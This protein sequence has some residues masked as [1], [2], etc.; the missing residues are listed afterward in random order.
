MRAKSIENSALPPGDAVVKKQV[1]WRQNYTR[2]ACVPTMILL[3]FV[4]L[5]GTEGL[6][7]FSCLP[8]QNPWWS[9]GRFDVS[10]CAT[11]V[12]GDNCAVSCSGPPN[13]ISGSDTSG[14]CTAPLEPAVTSWPSCA[15]KA[16]APNAPWMIEAGTTTMTI[17]WQDMGLNDCGEGETG[18]VFASWVLNSKASSTSSWQSSTGT[19]NTAVSCASYT[20]C[21]FNALTANTRHDFKVKATCTDSNLNSDWSGIGTHSTLPTPAG[22]PESLTVADSATTSIKW[23][24]SYSA[25]RG[26][27]VHAGWEAQIREPSGAWLKSPTGCEWPHFGQAECRSANL[28]CHRH[29]QFRVRELCD[30][31]AANSPWSTALPASTLPTHSYVVV[32][33]CSVRAATAP[34]WFA[35]NALTQA[36]YNSLILTWAAGTRNSCDFM[37]WEVLMQ[38]RVGTVESDWE[39]VAGCDVLVSRSVVSCTAMG[40]T[41]PEYRY[42]VRETCV[43]PMANSITSI[44]SPWVERILQQ[45]DTP[46]NVLLSNASHT[47]LKLTWGA[48]TLNDCLFHNYTVRLSPHDG[49]GAA[50]IVWTS[51]P[52]GC[53]YNP[54]IATTE[55]ELKN[56]ASGTGYVASV[57][58]GCYRNSADSA[59]AA[60]TPRATTLP[61]LATT[62]SPTTSLISANGLQVSWTAPSA[63][64]SC[65]FVRWQFEARESGTRVW[66][67][68]SGA[69]ITISPLQTRT[70]AEVHIVELSCDSTYH[71]R[72]R[73]VCSDPDANSFWAYVAPFATTAGGACAKRATPPEDVVAQYA[74][75]HSLFV[76]FRPGEART[77]EFSRFEVQYLAAN[78]WVSAFSGD[79]ASIT[80]RENPTCTAN[81]LVPDTEYYF[82]AREVCTVS[83][84]TSQWSMTVKP[85]RTL[86]AVPLT[87]LEAIPRGDATVNPTHM[88]LVF[89]EPVMLASNRWTATSWAT[90]CSADVAND[91]TW[92]FMQDANF[93]ADAHVT[94]TAQAAGTALPSQTTKCCGSTAC[95]P[96]CTLQTAFS[97]A[98]EICPTV[99]SKCQCADEAACQAEC[100]ELPSASGNN[101]EL[102]SDNLTAQ[103]QFPDGLPKVG[104]PYIV[105]ISRASIHTLTNPAR[106]ISATSWNFTYRPAAPSITSMVTVSS[107]ATS[108]GI[109]VAWTK[110]CSFTCRSSPLVELSTLGEY[111]QVMPATIYIS[112]L[113]PGAGYTIECTGVDKVLP[114]VQATES[115]CCFRTDYDTNAR[116]SSLQ[117]KVETL[118]SGV[119]TASTYATLSPAFNADST[120]QAYAV[121]VDI[122]GYK[123]ACGI[124]PSAD[125][126]VFYRVTVEPVAASTFAT[127]VMD[128]PLGT[129][130]STMNWPGNTIPTTS[131]TQVIT[132]N[133]QPHYLGGTQ[134]VASYPVTITTLYASLQ[135]ES[136]STSVDYMLPTD[137]SASVTV[138]CIMD[139]SLVSSMPLASLIIKFGIFTQA[140]A[141]G[142]Q[143]DVT[144]PQG[145]GNTMKRFTLIAGAASAYGY[146]LPV[147]IAYQSQEFVSSPPHTVSFVGPVVN[148]VDIYVGGTQSSTA[149][150]L[151]TNEI[152]V[153]GFN[154]G[155]GS[156]TSGARIRVSTTAALV[157]DILYLQMTFTG[158]QSSYNGDY[159]VIQAG[160]PFPSP[161]A[162][163]YETVCDRT[164]PM[165]YAANKGVFCW[166]SISNTWRYELVTSGSAVSPTKLAEFNPGNYTPNPVGATMVSGTLA[167]TDN[168][169]SLYLHQSYRLT[170][171]S[172]FSSYDGTYTLILP[173]HVLWHSHASLYT[174]CDTRKHR[175]AQLGT[176]LCWVQSQT[177]WILYQSSGATAIELGKISCTAYNPLP[178][179]CS[180][181]TGQLTS[182]AQARRLQDTTDKEIYNEQNDNKFHR[183]SSKRPAP[184]KLSTTTA[185]NLCGTTTYISTTEVRCSFEPQLQAQLHVML[186]IQSSAGAWVAAAI[187]DNY[188]SNQKVMMQTPTL[189]SITPSVQDWYSLSNLDVTGTNFPANS[190]MVGSLQIWVSASSVTPTLPNPDPADYL[191]L[192]AGS[193]RTSDTTILCV[194]NTGMNGSILK[195]TNPNVWLQTSPTMISPMA[196]GLISL[197]Q[198]NLSR[199][200]RSNDN[201]IAPVRFQL[202]GSE[203]GTA[204]WNGDL[205]VSIVSKGQATQ[206]SNAAPFLD[207][208]TTAAPSPSGAS[209]DASNSSSENS[210]SGSRLLTAAQNDNVTVDCVIVYRADGQITCDVTTGSLFTDSFDDRWYNINTTDPYHQY[211]IEVVLQYVNTSNPIYSSRIEARM[212][213]QVELARCDPGNRRV[214]KDVKTCRECAQ[215]T[216]KGISSSELHCHNCSIGFWQSATGASKCIEC[217][218]DNFTTWQNASASRYNCLCNEG[219]YRERPLVDPGPW[220]TGICLACPHGGKCDGR[221]RRPYSRAGYWSPGRQIFWDCQPPHACEEGTYRYRNKCAVSRNAMSRVCSMCAALYYRYRG[222]CY[223]C[224]FITTTVSQAGPLALV[225]LLVFIVVPCVIRDHTRKHTVLKLLDALDEEKEANGEVEEDPKV[226]KA[227]ARGQKNAH[228]KAKKKRFKRDCCD[229][230]AKYCDPCKIC[231]MLPLDKLPKFLQETIVQPRIRMVALVFSKFQ[232]LWALYLMPY[233]WPE[234]LKYQNEWFAMFVFDLDVIRPECSINIEY[235]QKFGLQ[236]LA[237]FFTSF[238]I[239]LG[240]KV[241]CCLYSDPKH[242]KYVHFPSAIRDALSTQACL[243]IMSHLSDDL[244]WIKCHPCEGGTQQCLNEH[245]IIK[246]NTQDLVFG[247]ITVVS[248]VDIGLVICPAVTYI[249]FGLYKSWMW[250]HGEGNG[251]NRKGHLPWHIFVSDFWVKGYKGYESNLRDEALHLGEYIRPLLQRGK[252][253]KLHDMWDRCIF[254]TKIDKWHQT[255]KLVETSIFN[256]IDSS[257]KRRKI[258]DANASLEHI[259]K[260]D[261]RIFRCPKRGPCYYLLCC[262]GC[263]KKKTVV[264]PSEA[265]KSNKK[266][267]LGKCLSRLCFC[268]KLCL[269]CCRICFMADLPSRPLPR[270]KRP[271]PYLQDDFLE[272]K[273]PMKR[274]NEVVAGSPKIGAIARDK[275]YREMTLEDHAKEAQIIHEELTQA[276]LKNA[277]MQKKHD[278]HQL[279]HLLAATDEFVR[280]V[281]HC[282]GILDH[283]SMFWCYSWEFILLVQKILTVLVSSLAPENQAQQVMSACMFFQLIVLIMC[284]DLEPF[285]WNVLNDI[286]I[287]LDLCMLYMVILAQLDW[288]LSLQVVSTG[289]V[290]IA[291]T[292]LTLRML[293]PSL[294]P[295]DVFDDQGHVVHAPKKARHVVELA[296]FC[297]ALGVPGMRKLKRAQ[298]RFKRKYLLTHGTQDQRE[299]AAA[300]AQKEKKKQKKEIVEPTMRERIEKLPK[301]LKGPVEAVAK[302]GWTKISWP[303]NFSAAHL[304]ANAGSTEAIQILHELKADLTTMDQWELTPLDYAEQ[305]G[306]D[307]VLKLIRYLSPNATQLRS[308]TRAR[309]ANAAKQLASARNG[310]G[311]SEDASPNP[312]KIGQSVD[313]SENE[314]Q[315]LVSNEVG[316][317][318]DVAL[319]QQGTPLRASSSSRRGRPDR[320]PKHRSHAGERGERGVVTGRGNTNV[321]GHVVKPG[322]L[323]PE[324]H[325][326]RMSLWQEHGV[327]ELMHKEVHGFHAEPDSL[328]KPTTNIRNTSAGGVSRHGNGRGHSE[329]RSVR[330]RA[331]MSAPPL[332]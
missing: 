213:L 165:W 52:A 71:L 120:G 326:Q 8:L 224:N 219:W 2:Q 329:G 294:P 245:P 289:M 283:T 139:A 240:L 114:T 215:G 75:A 256:I 44:P 211:P 98:I 70:T 190:M 101:F 298:R 316:L 138:Q 284:V 203:F 227:M 315:P 157:T 280:E 12:N 161:Y 74:S 131:S 78:A 10:A 110:P 307:D 45:A 122:S 188:A 153:K 192:C 293:L 282:G 186:E 331:N 275:G 189:T 164:K 230:L 330:T 182:L 133:V 318:A 306:F 167:Y 112:N 244:I 325:A 255:E 277:A 218:P 81:G 270:H 62:L 202:Y 127:V 196:S 88:Y 124:A 237:P 278:L 160:Y 209:S 166:S 48:G 195:I 27:C 121:S 135:I 51:H 18:G 288:S 66:F 4:R 73:E 96:I 85:G 59:W 116:L 265:K 13:Y 233:A 38:Y 299:E 146:N 285:E 141:V 94:C 239:F 212:T 229:I 290:V 155:T 134:N 260:K 21:Q 206:P 310:N 223:Q 60:S 276:K 115:R 312:M 47:T 136:V 156:G 231:H 79:C 95:D 5:P 225:I 234:F 130:P 140:T 242:D 113:S 185:V 274:A 32:Y 197:P 308:A 36:T 43:D 295:G 199:I 177:A 263:S 243:Q 54:D 90:G 194:R 200:D 1:Q 56:L 169:G 191:A 301:T 34:T 35:L 259:H 232:L 37:R 238:V 178:H 311:V 249:W 30:D 254:M 222:D 322:K 6:A 149:S 150:V 64:A 321:R 117:V 99:H 328:L 93:F 184:R 217:A 84:L 163:V 271:N 187:A 31:P 119:S 267:C 226:L 171:A 33:D 297:E 319:L 23:Q 29:Y 105:T 268:C 86:K 53:N 143:E 220:G 145:T 14:A 314:S 128:P 304:A 132:V 151:Q 25:T 332:D 300:Q 126:Q 118:C 168:T 22:A 20:V 208:A 266:S 183:P 179:T 40:L 251:V 103:Y 327:Q 100:W 108:I 253:D 106:F 180:A 250:Q 279:L 236:W 63:V 235:H 152:R 16:S 123:T 39:Q 261:H 216:Y 291:I 89:S 91:S 287:V 41:Q 296:V 201:E 193:T 92:T 69:D 144:D 154:F 221:K 46:T 72:M 125:A 77:C 257:I 305:G 28:V 248:L 273:V 67:E 247:A 176:V 87:I 76:T 172:A 9:D 82:R 317:E 15:K 181:P 17:W 303:S 111:T 162:A 80:P 302:V 57:L 159:S 24:W 107:T 205:V 246:C 26:H 313:D 173:A 83:T 58:V 292:P 50:A 148:Q 49:T 204:S 137:G 262:G 55:C 252:I 264:K 142:T 323:L 214:G 61:P 19:C 158:A 281:E 207:L 324:H 11:K 104:C 65:T 258:K 42:I 175:W 286:E 272:K 174:G 97:K 210:S 198:F 170:F 102:L 228:L 241:H 7:Q 147:I 309:G 3:C 109:A 129:R 269:R 68:P 320:S